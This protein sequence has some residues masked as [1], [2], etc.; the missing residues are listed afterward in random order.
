MS[1][2]VQ[3]AL[4]HQHRRHRA[5]AAVQPALDDRALGGAVWVGLQ[6]EQLGLQDDGLFQLVEAGALG[7]ADLH[8]LRV[9]AHFLHHDLVAEQFLAHAGRVGVRLVHLVD[10]HDDRRARRLGVTD[11]LDRLR[12]HAVIGGHHQHHDVGHRCTARA[13]G[14]ECLVARR[15]DEG[16]LVARRHLHLVG[17][18]VLGDPA[19]LAAYHIGRPQRVQQAGLA[20]VDVAHDRDHGGPWDHVGVDIGIALDP[21]LHVAFTDA[22]GTVAEFLHDQLGGIGVE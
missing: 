11:R 19:G 4:L 15:V 8:V 1:P 7:G 10:G 6:V 13:H 3:R 21:D 14:G 16:D 2:R 9:A 20:V 5:T 22:A 17:A 12:H 18:N